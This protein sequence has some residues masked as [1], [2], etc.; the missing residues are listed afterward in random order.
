MNPGSYGEMIVHARSLRVNYLEIYKEKIA[1]TCPDFFE[2]I[3]DEDIELVYQHK[4]EGKS[5]E[6][7][8]LL[9]K[10]LYGNE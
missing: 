7:N 3:N 1:R 8:L 9:Y 5:K 6:L 10:V 2:S 4:Y